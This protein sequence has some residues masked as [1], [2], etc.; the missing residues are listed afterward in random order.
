MNKIIKYFLVTTWILIGILVLVAI[1]HTKVVMDNY[2]QVISCLFFDKENKFNWIGITSI[3]AIVTL[4]FNA[5]DRRRQFRA[6][7]VSK[8][9]IE[10]IKQIRPIISDYLNDA[11]EYIY[12]TRQVKSYEEN[13]ADKK[14]IHEEITKKNNVYTSFNKNYTLLMLIIPTNS[15]NIKIIAPI[16]EIRLFIAKLD[17]TKI[18]K[19][20]M[21][22]K[23]GSL[24]E[25]SIQ[26]I[27]EYLKNEWERAK[28]GK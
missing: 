13:N 5:W 10:W 28:K 23:A 1:I 8:S 3:L 21:T 12:E 24:V 17:I 4:T 26:T 15:S 11:V 25:N 16:K 14:R 20:E 22:L 7:L 2:R 19:D 6:D 27:N 18:E 9:R